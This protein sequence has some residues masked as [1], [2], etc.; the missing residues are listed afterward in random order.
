MLFQAIAGPFPNA[1]NESLARLRD[2]TP[3]VLLNA[4]GSLAEETDHRLEYVLEGDRAEATDFGTHE[5]YVGREYLSGTGK[6]RALQ[7]A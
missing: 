6:T 2:N 3:F 7:R 4:S 1:A 5:G